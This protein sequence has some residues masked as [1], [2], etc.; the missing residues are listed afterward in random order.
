VGLRVFTAIGPV[1]VDVGYNPYDRP[2]GPAY[3]NTR[4]SGSE[5]ELRPVYCVSP[6]NRL[7]V[8]AIAI[9]VPVQQ[10]GTCPATF[11]PA[12]RRGFFNRLTFNFSIGQ[13]F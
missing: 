5:N 1:R 11:D 13:A 3:F 4:S 12:P 7:P 2:A 6:D 10:A 8:P 9:G